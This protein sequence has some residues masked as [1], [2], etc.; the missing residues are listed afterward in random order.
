MSPEVAIKRRVLAV[1]RRL[2]RLVLKGRLTERGYR[3]QLR[4]M[5]IA[6]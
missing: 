2:R 6:V 5:G 1:K 4:A 3:R